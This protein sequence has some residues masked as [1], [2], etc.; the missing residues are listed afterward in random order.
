MAFLLARIPYAQ[1]A[2][3]SCKYPIPQEYASLSQCLAGITVKDNLDFNWC[4]C[5]GMI[6]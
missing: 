5:R 3:A 6:V 4:S 1:L 2:F